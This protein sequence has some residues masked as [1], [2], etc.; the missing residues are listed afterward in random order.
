ML[1]AKA[2]V[3]LAVASPAALGLRFGRNARYAAIGNGIGA[4]LM[5]ACGYYVS[6]RAAFFLT[7]GLS[8]PALVPLLPLTRLDYS[9][10][11]VAGNT[12]TT[13]RGNP[14]NVLGNR[15]LLVFA[16]A[17]ML[18]TLGNA[19]MLPLVGN[20]PT[21]TVGNEA[22]PVIGASMVVPQLIVALVSPQIG[23]LSEAS[24]RRLVLLLGLLSLPIRGQCS[25]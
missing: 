18:F 11:L 13:P 3:S 25:R 1:W 5:G 6:A 12:A 14:I 22:S 10:S 19:A 2:G 24:G 16:G 17:V 8:L 9:H 21:K 20:T 4:V 15:P 7:A 23:R